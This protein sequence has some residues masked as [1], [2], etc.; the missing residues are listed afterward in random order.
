M[1]LGNTV[2]LHEGQG[3]TRRDKGRED[4]E[5]PGT[6]REDKRRQEK[7]RGDIGRHGKTMRENRIWVPRFNL[8]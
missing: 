2:K 8:R 5:R 4:T 7:I 1:T 6:A 3:K